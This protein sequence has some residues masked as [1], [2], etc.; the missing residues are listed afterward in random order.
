[1]NAPAQV[2]WWA[3]RVLGLV[4]VMVGE[5]LGFLAAQA[6]V[7]APMAWAKRMQL[8]PGWTRFRR[9]KAFR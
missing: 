1:M 6:L 5:I 4:S 9:S 7:L 2:P 8:K 3:D